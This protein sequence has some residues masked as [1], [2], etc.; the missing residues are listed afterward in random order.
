MSVRLFR[1]VVHVLFNDDQVISEKREF[2]R[3]PR[4]TS[5]TVVNCVP[6]PWPGSDSLFVLSTLLLAMDV[7]F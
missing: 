1:S 5:V 7:S 4:K 3:K 6:A 2:L